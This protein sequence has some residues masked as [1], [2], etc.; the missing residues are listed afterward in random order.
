MV[1]GQGLQ[2]ILGFNYG[3]KRYHLALKAVSIA[4]VVSTS[5][6]MLAF[7]V[8]YF[9]PE[10]IM[11]VFTNDA[12]L[13]EMG[14]YASR[15]VFLSMPLMGVVMIGQTIFQAIGKALQSFI[16]AIVRPVVFLIPAVLLMSHL[17][18]LDGVFLA[19]PISDVLTLILVLVLLSPIINQFRRDAAAFKAG[20]TG[21]LPAKPLL[22][23][24][25]SGGILK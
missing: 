18:Q 17:W 14:T 9:F 1:F 12:P 8:L 16:T 7:L 22:D 24:S 5:L 15:L 23:S 25:E 4:A 2:P 19:F 21:P 3:A 11:R 10:P 6:S 13:V 20:K